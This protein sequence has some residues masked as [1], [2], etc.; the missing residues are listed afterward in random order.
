M[1][2]LF[3]FII[4]HQ[5]PGGDRSHIPK[6]PPDWDIF[7]K[8][9]SCFCRWLILPFPSAM[10][11]LFPCSFSL[12]FQVQRCIHSHVRSRNIKIEKLARLVIGHSVTVHEDLEDSLGFVDHARS[13][14]VPNHSRDGLVI[15]VREQYLGFVVTV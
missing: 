3:T 9:P 12:C 2:C 14:A 8:I 7:L 4:V 1:P 10:P 6:H 5:I 15:A 13:L 11:L